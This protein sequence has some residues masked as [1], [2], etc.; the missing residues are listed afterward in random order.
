MKVFWSG[1]ILKWT[2]LIFSLRWSL[3]L[4]SCLE[5]LSSFN[6]GDV[7]NLMWCLLPGWWWWKWAFVSE[8]TRQ[9][10]ADG[11]ESSCIQRSEPNHCILRS[12]FFQ[13]TMLWSSCLGH[14]VHFSIFER[15]KPNKAFSFGHSARHCIWCNHCGCSSL[16]FAILRGLKISAVN[17]FCRSLLYIIGQKTVHNVFVLRL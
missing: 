3:K 1:S 7:I 16:A 14:L 9:E 5:Q 6:L 17:A 2:L 13:E 12:K 10:E 15:G 11:R 8:W 4:Q